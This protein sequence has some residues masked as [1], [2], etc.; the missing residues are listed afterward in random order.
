[1]PTGDPKIPDYI[2]RAKEIHQDFIERTDGSVG[3]ANDDDVDDNTSNINGKD[4][5]EEN[6][7]ELENY[8]DAAQ[9]FIPPQPDLELNT[10]RPMS[11]STSVPAVA[12]AAAA[13]A[14]AAAASAAAAAAAAPTTADAA[15]ASGG[16]TRQPRAS[17]PSSSVSRFVK[18]VSGIGKKPASSK[19]DEHGFTVQSAMMMMMMMQQNQDRTMQQQWKEEDRQRRIEKEEVAKLEREE[20]IEMFRLSL[21]QQSLAQQANQQMMTMMMTMMTG[22]VMSSNKRGNTSEGNDNN[23]NKKVR[24]DVD[25]E[26][27]GSNEKE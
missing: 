19:A 22:G 26:N 20:R 4:V 1:M 13:T 6:D 2:K 18:Q 24:S 21:Q 25:N 8:F 17:P 14:A 12:A 23:P 10:P 7:E 3:A 5:E 15:T 16:D 11:R 27:E 9:L